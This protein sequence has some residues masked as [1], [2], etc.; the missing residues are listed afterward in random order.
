MKYTN[1]HGLSPT[2][3]ESLKYDDYD[4]GEFS[5]QTPSSLNSPV[6][7]KK[8]LDTHQD[9]LEKDVVDNFHLMMG[10]AVHKVLETT[11]ASVWKEIRVYSKIQ[12]WIISA[13]LDHFWLE[14]GALQ[15][16]KNT[17]TYKFTLDFSGRLP[18]VPEWEA[19]LN[20]IAYILRNQPMVEE[21]GELVP[22]FPP[23][24]KK[25]QIVGLLKDWSRTKA[26]RDHKY[27]QTPIF[28]RDIPFWEDARIVKYITER[29]AAHDK[30]KTQDISQ[31]P[32]C[33]DEETW[34]KPTMYAVMK[35]NAKKSTKNFLDYNQ[36]QALS[37]Q[38]PG[39]FVET[40]PGVR[41]RCES[42]CDASKFCP[43]YT[44]WKQQNR[45]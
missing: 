11:G 34:A 25:L 2:I 9:E 32:P 15:D 19:Q 26:Q 45:R 24:I 43:F 6:Y 17:T 30:A 10:K 29:A 4:P 13:Q 7:M 8:L 16:Y 20:T 21:K 33:S 41:P 23:E 22:F 35:Q 27:P 18:E 3:V 44:Q 31:I 38:I 37:N 39:S 36:A 42:Y 1:K 28:P 12:K 40:R 5:N 14:E